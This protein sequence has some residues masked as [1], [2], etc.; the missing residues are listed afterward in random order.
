LAF[1]LALAERFKK[2]SG[3]AIAKLASNDKTRMLGTSGDCPLDGTRRF[4]L[5][6]CG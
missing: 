5:N 6:N 1:Q 4:R 2:V 3:T